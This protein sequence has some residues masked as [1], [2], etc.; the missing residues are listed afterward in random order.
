MIVK[1]G[2]SMFIFSKDWGEKKKIFETTT[3]VSK[4]P[5]W[6]YSPYKWPKW[7]VNRGY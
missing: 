7:L 4:S 5:N 1:M 6:G 3:M 2:S